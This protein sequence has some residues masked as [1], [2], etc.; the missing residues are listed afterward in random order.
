MATISEKIA[1]VTARIPKKVA[2]AAGALA[3]VAGCGGAYYYFV[4][5]PQQ[6]AAAEATTTVSTVPRKPPV[7][8]ATAPA[9]AVPATPVV[10]KTGPASA[11][12]SA[13]VATTATAAPKSQ[14][15]TTEKSKELK[16]EPDKNIKAG[17]EIAA[18]GKTDKKAAEATSA[19]HVEPGAAA[20]VK[21]THKRVKARRP[22]HVRSPAP[23]AVVTDVVAP[24]PQVNVITTKFNDLIT[25]VMYQDQ[26]AVTELLD[27][28]WWVDKPDTSG[29]TP[30][31]A[32]ANIGN[33]AMAELLLKRGANPNLVSSRSDSA[34]RIAKHNRD[35]GMTALLQRHGAT[36]E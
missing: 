24:E 11:V 5:L 10:A 36:V 7:A 34:L 30:L 25:A 35:A 20:P 23:V 8:K 33:I 16:T 2:M 15:A 1:S 28:G 6:Q 32:A 14:L 27:L 3:V 22:R 29:I 21:A 13:P 9:A 31:M 26:A 4:Y 19:S 18:V 17:K 12:A